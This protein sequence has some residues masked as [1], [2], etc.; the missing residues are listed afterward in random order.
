MAKE[1]GIDSPLFMFDDE[2]NPRPK[3][4]ISKAKRSARRTTMLPS[5]LNV[6]LNESMKNRRRSSRLEALKKFENPLEVK[7]NWQVFD[8]EKHNAN[9]LTMLNSA[10]LQMLQKIPV[11]GPKAAFIIHR[12]R[13][14]HGQL[15]SVEALRSIPGLQKSF[16]NKFIKTHQIVLT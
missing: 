16:F 11:I 14:L 15:S 4:S 10:N 5:E 6:T 7:T 12:H 13:E 3:P 2:C 1:M 9:M 8:Q